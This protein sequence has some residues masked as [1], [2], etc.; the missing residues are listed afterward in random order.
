MSKRMSDSSI[1]EESDYCESDSMDSLMFYENYESSESSDE[2]SNEDISDVIDYE[3]NDSIDLI[4][5]DSSEDI[6]RFITEFETQYGSRHPVFYS[7]TYGQALN[8][9]KRELKF[10]LVYLHSDSH[11]D[12]QDFCH[13]ILTNN[14]LIEFI[15]QNNLLFW[16]CSVTYSEGYRVSQSLRE[17]TYPYLAL[18]GLK[19]NRMVLIRKF[20]GKQNLDSLLNQLRKSIEDNESS[21]IAARLEREERNMNQLI[22]KQQDEDFAE[23]L[24]ADQEKEKKKKEEKN[25]K[26]AEE[27]AKKEKELEANQ[28]KERLLQ[29]KLELKDKIPLEPDIGDPNA[30]KLVIKL[31]N[32]TRLERRF[33]KTQSIKYLYYFVFC[34]DE[35]LLNFQ[36]RTNFPTRDLPG[37]PPSL[38]DFPPN[39][40]IN[41]S[42]EEV[43]EAPTFDQCDLGKGAMLFVHDFE[44]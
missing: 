5:S 27:K 12:S 17:S 14:Q 32:G 22:R 10:L 20:E 7:G 19:H 33:L 28:R 29:L 36:I 37:K 31:P 24:R 11:Q 3:F 6:D 9:A 18:I 39:K 1:S 2:M 42:I 44:A 34:S 4:D 21:L 40:D 26:E 15:N 30:T 38:E 41:E 25:K 16:S 13:N 35:S 43:K 8:E 23:S